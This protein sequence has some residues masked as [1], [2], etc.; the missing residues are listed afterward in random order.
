[1]KKLAGLILAVATAAACGPDCALPVITP[2]LSIT[3]RDA[4]T[5][6]PVEDVTV[7]VRQ[8][9]VVAL[10]VTGVKGGRMSGSV[11]EGVYTIRIAK[12]GYEDWI[13]TGVT[14]TEGDGCNTGGVTLV[15]RLQPV[16]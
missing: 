12:D 1:M 4:V 9:D 6:A 8:G 15:A 13:R 10:K 5:G 11:G 7:E 3:V 14:V 2:S 16:P